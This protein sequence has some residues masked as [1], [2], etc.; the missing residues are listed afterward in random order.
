[1]SVELRDDMN[2]RELLD[3]CIQAELRAKVF[4]A[5]ANNY[6]YGIKAACRTQSIEKI[7]ELLTKCLTEGDALDMVTW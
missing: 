1:M 7:R 5:K 6:R 3:R 4:E 2:F